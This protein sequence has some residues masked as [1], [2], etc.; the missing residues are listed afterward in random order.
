[1]SENSNI[2]KNN[3]EID[4]KSILRY[5]QQYWY[6]YVISIV[7]YAA[8]GVIYVYKKSP[9]YESSCSVLIKQDNG[10]PEEMLLLQDLGLGG[11]KTNI[12]NEIGIIQSPDLIKNVVVK[13]GL[14]IQYKYNKFFNLNNPSLYQSTPII[15]SLKNINIDSLETTISF[16]IKQKEEKFD[17]EYIFYRNGGEVIGLE[18]N[19]QLPL[20]IKTQL[21]E[22]VLSKNPNINN[23]LNYPLNITITP[24]EIV[25]RSIAKNLNVSVSN[26]QSSLLNISI[27]CDNKK[28]GEDII[29]GILEEYN[30]DSKTDKNM[31]AHNTAIFIEERIKNLYEELNE[32]EG[33]VEQFRK[34]NEIADIP[35]QITNFIERNESYET[36][37]NEIITQK[38]LVSHLEKFINDINNSDKII[39]GTGITSPELNNIFDTYNNLILKREQIKKNASEKNPIL[40]QI[41]DQ[42]NGLRDNIKKAIS[43]QKAAIGIQLNDIDN[44]FVQVNS[45][46]RNIPKIDREFT[47]ILREQEVKSKLFV[48]LLQKRE[49]TNL[50]QAGVSEKAKFISKPFSKGSPIEPKVPITILS[51]II[52][53]IAFMTLIIFAFK[54]FQTKIRGLKDLDNLKGATVI[55]DIAKI[56]I[57]NI[58]VE[59]GVIVVKEDDDSAETEMFRSLRNNLLYMMDRESNKVILVTSTIPGEG[60]TFISA[61]IS[62]SLS[63]LDKKVI[64]VGCDLRNPQIFSAFGF[65][66]WE[67]GVSTILAGFEKNYRSLIHKLSNNLYIIPAGPI[68]PNPNELLTRKTMKEFILE[69]KQD[70]DYVVIDSAPV[71]VVTD[72]L[73]F[74]R[75]ADATLYVVKDEYSEKDTVE[76]INNMIQDNRILNTA[77]VLN[78][79]RERNKKNKSKYGYTYSYKY[80]YGYSA[81]NRN[82]KRA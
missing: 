16:N 48:F 14:Y 78:E 79:A 7:I 42:I 38:N 23:S 19:K 67:K 36:V 63:L 71:G 1:M 51:F 26:K 70:F 35:T 43:H 9:V 61:N 39:P 21:G 4:I 50:T 74:S 53:G 24:P 2:S 11:N 64:V 55:G 15:A 8:I 30:L 66:S 59:N 47:N 65:T 10:A 17:I 54:L 40:I 29:L 58:E 60:K 37:R 75:F 82:K 12:Q 57:K 25:A 45:K 27:K 68:P 80:K 41:N 52:A 34:T 28:M 72:T 81:D 5:I 20:T 77:V 44:K 33:D 18:E 3:E 49:E 6:Y 32:V 13:K 31:V 56:D 76:F 73:T 22:F 62:K 46:I 69:L